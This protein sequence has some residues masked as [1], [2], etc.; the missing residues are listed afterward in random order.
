MAE[1]FDLSG[2][3]RKYKKNLGLG[4]TKN[5]FIVS[6][7]F[8]NPQSWL[9]YSNLLSNNQVNVSNAFNNVSEA[10]GFPL[11]IP[12]NT[13]YSEFNKWFGVANSVQLPGY[14]LEAGPEVMKWA[15]YP[16]G[17]TKSPLTIGYFNDQWDINFQF[18]R[19]YV[20]SICNGRTLKYPDEYMCN[21]TVVVF[22]PDMTPLKTFIYER[23][24]PAGYTDL[25]H[26]YAEAK[27]AIPTFTV[28]MNWQDFRIIKGDT[29]F[30]IKSLDKL[31]KKT[32]SS[33][34]DAGVAGVDAAGQII[35]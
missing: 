27:T 1:A 18:W 34:I 20:S 23:C 7:D 16:K 15:S 22:N 32:R 31:I 29:V 21:V 2:Q 13:E 4:Y 19:N 6:V 11:S 5:R 8:I 35:P 14:L 25:D 3:L 17:A 12:V 33:S 30:P 24:Y 26:S 9:T 10:I 28:T